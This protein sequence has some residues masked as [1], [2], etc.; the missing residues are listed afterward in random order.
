M[1]LNLEAFNCN[2]L[3]QRKAYLLS[4]F[5][6]GDTAILCGLKSEIEKAYQE[7][8]ILV[9]KESHETILK[10]YEIEEYETYKNC[11]FDSNSNLLKI[12]SDS[13]K[14]PQKGKLYVAHYDWSP[15]RRLL[16][17][18]DGNL[19]FGMLDFYKGFLGLTWECDF[20][21][22]R[23]VPRSIFVED[24]LKIKLKLKGI[25]APLNKICLLIPEVHSLSPL[26]VKYWCDLAEKVK[27][28]GL[29][30]V[31]SVCSEDFEIPGIKNVSLTLQ[32]LITFSMLSAKVISMR[33]G[34]C[35]LIW[36]K[37]KDLYVVYPDIRTYYWGR[38]KSIF[39]DSD[40]TEVIA[41]S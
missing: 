3:D 4:P 19:F 27:D 36:P 35:D 30:P 12:I 18:Q 26:P 34:L 5:G 29:I 2:E 9:V 16:H 37:G 14:F 7:Q 28:D 33:S 32:E 1:T 22:P 17:I 11:R 10:M 13:V 8:V 38:L 41:R 25:N 21:Y 6:L 23:Q 40:A 20:R 31:T 39:P 24:Q 15:K